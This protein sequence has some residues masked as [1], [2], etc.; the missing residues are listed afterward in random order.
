MMP[1]LFSKSKLFSDNF[2][3]KNNCHVPLTTRCDSVVDYT[4]LPA[5]GLTF[6]MFKADDENLIFG[7]LQPPFTEHQ[8]R[9][10]ESQL[11]SNR[12]FFKRDL[13]QNRC[14]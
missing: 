8:R 6:V 4:P 12:H 1:S 14:H 10:V 5:R 3:H 13:K 2:T 7:F 11:P 9:W